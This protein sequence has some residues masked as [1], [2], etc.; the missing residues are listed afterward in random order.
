M[1]CISRVTSIKFTHLVLIHRVYS[2][3]AGYSNNNVFT[4]DLLLFPASVCSRRFFRWRFKYVLEYGDVFLK[5]DRCHSEVPLQLFC[6]LPEFLWQVGHIL[7]FLHFAEK[8]DQT[9]RRT[10]G[11]PFKWAFCNILM[12]R[13]YWKRHHFKS[14]P[15]F[16]HAFFSSVRLKPV[17]LPWW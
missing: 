16:H 4:H 2:I 10:E 9:R 15:S 1:F 8:L 11:L 3:V 7:P 6:A 14:F 17:A 13:K 5:N 12:F